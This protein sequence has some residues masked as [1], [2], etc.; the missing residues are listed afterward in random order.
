MSAEN[1]QPNPHQAELTQQVEAARQAVQANGDHFQDTSFGGDV[2]HEVIK[3]GNSLYD[4]SITTSRA[5][6]KDRVDARAT[7]D[8]PDHTGISTD[9]HAYVENRNLIG[10]DETIAATHVKRFDE[11]GKE[12]YS[13][14]FKNPDTARKFGS[15]IASQVTERAKAVSA[16]RKAA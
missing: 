5:S 10:E 9:Y 7:T 13:H 1:P 12:V 2:Q 3:P 11:N 6:Y 4:P 16:D 14:K 8:G 15:L